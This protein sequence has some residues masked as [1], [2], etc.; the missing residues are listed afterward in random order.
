MIKPPL[1]HL[2]RVW[3]NPMQAVNTS[4]QGVHSLDALDTLAITM[5]QW[6]MFR[7]VQRVQSGC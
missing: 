5:R 2:D 6:G 3:H 1:R 4:G 7:F